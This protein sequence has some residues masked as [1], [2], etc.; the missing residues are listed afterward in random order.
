MR[1][2]AIKSKL[3]TGSVTNIILSGGMEIYPELPCILLYDD[4]PLNTYYT[5]DNTINPFI[6]EVRYPAGYID[7]VDKYIEEE[8]LTLL[9]RKVLYD[10][11]N[12]S[13]VQTFATA[14]VTKLSEPND[15]R[16]LSKGNDDG[17]ISKARRFFTPRR[18][19]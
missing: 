10:T 2:N 16:A 12:D 1:L 17:T 15:D 19:L 11:E 9:D 8:V 5:Q 3:L 6:V 18:G 7:E 4:F 13:Y 14:N